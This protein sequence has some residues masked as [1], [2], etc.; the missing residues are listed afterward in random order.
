MFCLFS[1]VVSCLFSVVVFG[2]FLET[3]LRVLLVFSRRVLLVFRNRSSCFAC[4][5]SFAICGLFSV[6]MFDLIVSKSFKSLQ[7]FRLCCL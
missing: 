7:V 3:V 4:F 6:S 2:L 5:Q 1:V